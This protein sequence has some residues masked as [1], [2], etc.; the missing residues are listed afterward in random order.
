MPQPDRPRR[1]ARPAST[2]PRRVTSVAL[3]VE[4]ADEID[5]LA[6]RECRSRSW[7]VEEL[8]RDALCMPLQRVGA[9]E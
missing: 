9:D 2:T 8:L 7:M 6:A 1:P 5:R 4:V 3:S